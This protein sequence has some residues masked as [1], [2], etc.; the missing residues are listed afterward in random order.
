MPELAPKKDQLMILA[1]LHCHLHLWQG[2]GGMLPVTIG[3]MM[4]NTKAG[5]EAP[6]VIRML[7]G[8]VLNKFSEDVNAKSTVVPRQMMSLIYLATDRLREKYSK[9]QAAKLKSTEGYE[10]L[11]EAAKRRRT[12]EAPAD[13]SA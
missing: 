2:E 7:M 11:K 9:D 8:D 4:A 13:A 1:D 3:M 10:A 12:S 6:N 5:A